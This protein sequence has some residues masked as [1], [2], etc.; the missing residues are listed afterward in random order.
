VESVRAAVAR[1]W[2][3]VLA[4]RVGW[5]TGAATSAPCSSSNLVARLPNGSIRIRRLFSF[6]VG[7]NPP[8][9]GGAFRRCR[10]HASNNARARLPRSSRLDDL[11]GDSRVAPACRPHRNLAS[12][13][14][15][16]NPRWRTCD[17]DHQ[18]D[19]H[20]WPH[21]DCRRSTRAAPTADGVPIGLA[22]HR[23]LAVL[24]DGWDWRLAERSECKLTLFACGL[25]SQAPMAIGNFWPPTSTVSSVRYL[26]IHA[27]AAAEEGAL[28]V[29]TVPPRDSLG[30]RRPAVAHV[31]LI[32]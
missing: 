12:I 14:L 11:L 7:P 25:E 4:Q 23:G 9:V 29:T 16:L 1:S 17:P 18:A 32:D 13:R 15:T 19:R 24:T 31:K 6:E 21:Q 20:R 8:G 2:D 28:P 5:R 26:A 30:L 10:R 22:P 3:V 27:R